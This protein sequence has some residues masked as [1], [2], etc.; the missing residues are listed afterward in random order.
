MAGMWVCKWPIR[1]VITVSIRKWDW[2]WRILTIE[3]EFH[4][5]HYCKH[6]PIT[7]AALVVLVARLSARVWMGGSDISVKVINWFGFLWHHLLAS[8]MK[9]WQWKNKIITDLLSHLFDQSC[10]R[11]TI[12]LCA[13]IHNN[14]TLFVGRGWCCCVGSGDCSML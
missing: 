3:V 7:V 9:M 6:L 1:P 11:K 10:R 2:H 13:V 14:M 5:L 8:T 4:L 12:C